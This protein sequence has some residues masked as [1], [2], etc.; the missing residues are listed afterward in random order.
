MPYILKSK[1][2]LFDRAFAA[3]PPAQDAGDL[4]Y[5]FSRI[6]QRYI[7]AHGESYQRMND[8]VGALDGAKAE[9]QRVIVAPYE[10]HKRFLNGDIAP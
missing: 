9:F 1:R 10:D 6:A 5:L 7:A 2:S 3:M 4:N 8:V